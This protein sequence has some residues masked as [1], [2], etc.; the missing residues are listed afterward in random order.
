MIGIKVWIIKVS[1]SLP[2]QLQVTNYKRTITKCKQLE[3]AVVEAG[4]PMSFK[5][6]QK[7]HLS[8]ASSAHQHNTKNGF[9]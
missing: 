2:L 6:G 5:K 8:A 1:A 3:E 9:C 4:S 7:Q